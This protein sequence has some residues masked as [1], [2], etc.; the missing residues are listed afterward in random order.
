MSVGTVE[1]LGEG[2]AVFGEEVVQCVHRLCVDDGECGAL[3]TRGGDEAD[4][5]IGGGG[6]GAAV[7]AEDAT[8]VA[9]DG[10]GVRSVGGAV[11]CVEAGQCGGEA[12]AFTGEAR[13]RGG[14]LCGLPLLDALQ[15]ASEE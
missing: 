13:L 11:V 5:A 7:V 10:G 3:L 9:V 14:V 12:D 1:G 8:E 6:V 4:G 15:R 2:F